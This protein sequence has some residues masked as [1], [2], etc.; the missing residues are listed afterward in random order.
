MTD[1]RNHREERSQETWL[2]CA[3]NRKGHGGPGTGKFLELLPLKRKNLVFVQQVFE[4]TV[5]KEALGHNNMI[6]LLFMVRLLYP[7]CC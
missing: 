7:E 3:V 4:R 2:S 6:L 5:K 1:S